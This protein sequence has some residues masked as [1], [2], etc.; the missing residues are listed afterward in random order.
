MKP[1]SIT[2]VQDCPATN[3]RGAKLRRRQTFSRLADEILENIFLEDIF[4][5]KDLC[6]LALVS[7]RFSRWAQVSLYSQIIIHLRGKEYVSFYRTLLEH[8]ELGSF[9]WK[10]SLRGDG[11]KYSRESEECLPNAQSLLK[12]LPAL[13]SLE[14]VWFNCSDGSTSLFDNRMSHLRT[15]LSCSYG[16]VSSIQLV[17]VTKAITFPQLKRLFMGFDEDWKDNEWEGTHEG[18]VFDALAGTSPLKGLHL[19]GSINSIIHDSNFLKVPR[20]LETL[21]CIFDKYGR[22]APKATID[23]LRPLYSTLVVLR[24]LHCRSR[25]VSGPV[26]DFSSFECLKVLTV[27]DPFCLTVWSSERPDERC[28]LYNRLP[29]TLRT[30][31]VSFQH[32][33]FTWLAGLTN[34]VIFA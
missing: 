1:L 10:A 17:D 2:D 12:L 29:F 15:I 13:R 31:Q 7:R 11:D 14:V 26:S 16:G 4:S 33:I 22:L 6:A 3:T 24:L 32:A 20:A 21:T 19:A 5:Q 27:D 8:P 9:V 34:V 18:T 25:G 23:A 30:L 28:G